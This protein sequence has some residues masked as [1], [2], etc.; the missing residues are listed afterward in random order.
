MYPELKSTEEFETAVK[1]TKE[2]MNKELEEF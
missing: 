1:E 2:K